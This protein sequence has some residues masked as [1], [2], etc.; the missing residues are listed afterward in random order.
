MGITDHNTKERGI[1]MD[2]R[3]LKT[4]KAI[5]DAYFSLLLSGKTKIS[6][7]EIARRADIDRKTFYLHYQSVEDIV[8]AFAKETLYELLNMLKEHGFYSE[9]YDLAVFFSALNEL[10]MKDIDLYRMLSRNHNY[11]FFWDTARTIINDSINEVYLKDKSRHNSKEIQTYIDFYTSGIIAVYR[12][13]LGSEDSMSLDE[14][15]KYLSRI[16]MTAIQIATDIR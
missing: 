15:G 4:D 2:R 6:V 7:A 8:V 1:N 12:R 9:P 3:F 13:W 16:S 11:D 10:M 14:L 5:R